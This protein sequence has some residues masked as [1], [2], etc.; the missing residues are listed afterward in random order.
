MTRSPDSVLCI[1]MLSLHSVMSDTTLN[2]YCAWQTSLTSWYK[3]SAELYSANNSCAAST[4]MWKRLASTG[5]LPVVTRQLCFH[6][7]VDAVGGTVAVV[8]GVI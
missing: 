2:R 4:I 8:A 7:A 1:F 3:K 5:R 6:L